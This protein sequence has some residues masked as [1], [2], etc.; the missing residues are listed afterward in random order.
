MIE[1]PALCAL[2]AVAIVLV[3]EVVCAILDGLFV[4]YVRRRLRREGRR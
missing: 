2:Y 1:D 4:L 3:A